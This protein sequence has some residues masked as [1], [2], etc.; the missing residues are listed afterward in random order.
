[1]LLHRAAV[2]LEDPGKESD[3][4]HTTQKTHRMPTAQFLNGVE[5]APIFV[6]ILIS[7]MEYLDKLCG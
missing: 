5:K 3:H 1:M 4:F 7:P 6:T 2:K